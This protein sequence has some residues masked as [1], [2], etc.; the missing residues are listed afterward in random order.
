MSLGGFSINTCVLCSSCLYLWTRTGGESEERLRKKQKQDGGKASKVL[1]LLSFIIPTVGVIINKDKA[2]HETWNEYSILR[3]SSLFPR[4]LRGCSVC[5]DRSTHGEKGGWKWQRQ[6]DKW[7]YPNNPMLRTLQD[8]NENSRLVH[9][10]IRLDT[11]ALICQS[12]HWSSLPSQACCIY[13]VNPRHSRTDFQRPC[14]MVMQKQTRSHYVI[15]KAT[16]AVA[17]ISP[18]SFSLS[19]S[20]KSA[21]QQCANKLACST[22][23]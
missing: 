2:W 16:H 19:L 5:R 15:T 13:Y 11:D 7:V 17:T 3:A 12:G 10:N 9:V 4:V 20:G 23:D 1:C 22:V 21:I 18:L 14:Y 8:P 6:E